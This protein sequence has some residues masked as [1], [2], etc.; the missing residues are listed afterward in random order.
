[1]LDFL[2]SS[3]R[4]TSLLVDLA[5]RNNATASVANSLQDVGLA[6][7]R[8]GDGPMGPTTLRFKYN[9]DA[10]HAIVDTDSVGIPADL[11]VKGMAGIPTQMPSLVKAIGIPAKLLRQFVVLNPLYSARQLFRDSTAAAIASGAN[12]TPVLSSIKHLS[13]TESRETLESRG[14]TGGQVLQGTADDMTALLRGITAGG[15]PM[16]SLAKWESAS[17][18]AD[19]ATRAAQYDSYRKQGLSELEATFM[20]LESMNFNR[21]GVSANVHWV[22]HMVPFFNA[23]IQGLDVLYRAFRGRMPMQERLQI[24]EKLLK[25]GALLMATSMAYALAM[26]DDEA[27]KNATPEERAANFFVP[28]PGVDEAVRIPIPFEIGYIF[29][30]LPE[31]VLNMALREDGTTE[32]KKALNAIILQ[33][34]P[35]GSSMPTVD[36]RGANV[37]IPIIL[38][39]AVKPAV[40]LALGKSFYTRR[41][42]ESEAE[43]SLEA[44]YRYRDTTSEL[45]KTLGSVT[46]VSPIMVEN[47]VRGY[48]SGLG[49]ALMQAFSFA[50]PTADGPEAAAKTLSK[51]P[52]VG[53]A[54]QPADGSGVLN[55]T[56]DRIKEIEQTKRTY[57]QL[58]KRGERAEAERY[59]QEKADT[60]ALASAGGNVKQMLGKLTQLEAAV[61][62]SDMSPVEKREM[63]IAVR[64]QKLML[65]EAGRSA[66]R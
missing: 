7:V 62:A 9:G 26:Q 22:S 39:T 50:M 13:R 52:I 56:Y 37:P 11:L 49:V 60:L 14:I 31:M 18:A 36:V 29:K 25:R 40:E 54:F 15:S 51:L 55:L 32:A 35:G 2:T 10:Y 4:N 8:E 61:R 17:M 12:L 23:Q 41:D 27:Y 64:Q 48:T 44:K 21:R 58:V 16:L 47:T 34:I 6:Q 3:V 28:L 20:A 66:L 59:L 24:R 42:I 45:A 65:A 46:G 19:A 53:P 30:A 5:L 38:P 63:L 57:E 43:Q 33:T 1:V